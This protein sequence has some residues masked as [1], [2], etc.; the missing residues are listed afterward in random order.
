MKNSATVHE[1]FLHEPLIVSVEET[2][3]TQESGQYIFIVI[4]N[5][6]QIALKSIESFCKTDFFTIYD[7]QDL[8]DEYRVTYK[9]WPHHK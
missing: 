3:M 8:Q 9:S 1:H 6:Y 5:E 7:T 4:K 2:N